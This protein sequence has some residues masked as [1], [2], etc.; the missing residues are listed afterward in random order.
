LITE[1]PLIDQ[2]LRHVRRKA[3]ELGGDPFDLTPEAA[4]PAMLCPRVL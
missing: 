3:E 1:G 2:L 4:R